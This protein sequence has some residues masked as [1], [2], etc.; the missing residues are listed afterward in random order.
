VPLKQSA[1]HALARLTGAV[2]SQGFREAFV[3]DVFETDPDVIL[4]VVGPALNRTPRLE[5][6]PLDLNPDDRLEFEDLAGLFASTSLNHGVV[7]MTI[8]QVAYIFGTARRTGAKKAIEIG[9]WRGGTTVT[10]S[11]A[12]GPGSKLWSIDVGEKEAHLFEGRPAA[13]D[14]EARN[15]CERFGLDVELLV[16]DSRTIE[17]DTGEVDLVLIDGDHSYE[18]AKNDF[19]RFGTRVSVGGHILFDDA[20]PE[21][22]FTTHADTVGRLVE[23]ITG[24]GDY[25]LAA[26][27]DRLA[28]LERVR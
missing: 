3:R 12:M 4:Q 5:T 15:F 28:D 10:L 21:A 24:T 27:V 22:L 26:K 8:R 9:R 7:G 14:T 2:P 13:F 18:G 23:E 25:R 19:D 17:V 11:A 20:F 6:M 1:I 16:G